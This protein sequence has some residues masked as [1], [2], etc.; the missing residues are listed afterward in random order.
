MKK[1]G[2]ALGG[3]G[4]RGYAHI[5]VLKVI[6]KYNI[7]VNF[8]VGSSMGSII[9]ACYA[10]EMPIEE[11]EKTASNM[12]HLK[13]LQ[14]LDFN[15]PRK[16]LIS[17]KILERYFDELIDGKTFKDLKIPLV[18]TATDIIT[19]REIVIKEGSVAKAVRASI[20]IP[21]IFVPVKRNKYILADG[22]IIN[23][24]P[25]NVA[26]AIGSD[27]VI[28]VDVSSE[29]DSITSFIN[30]KKSV[31]GMKNFFEKSRYI[32]KER[33]GNIYRKI[34]NTIPDVFKYTYR[35][36]QLVELDTT[37]EYFYS[38]CDNNDIII[39]KPD[40]K[41]IKWYKFNLAGECIKRG[42]ISAVDKAEV[43]AE[44]ISS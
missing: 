30:I 23:F 9:G 34:R 38:N 22:S 16:G 6:E 7:P 12:S 21:G 8:I 27:I 2:L 36:L 14:L 35:S 29:I 17:G 3:G 5:G 39:I 26:K 43:I 44:R 37:K 18:V 24:L 33:H 15:F 42:F 28:A 41:D 10:A 19:G 25:V 40:I 31:D 1:V 4:A 32:G 13:F 20:S 11:I